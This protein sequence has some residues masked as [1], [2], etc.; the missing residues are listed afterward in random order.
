[1]IPVPVPQPPPG[2][3]ATALPGAAIARS[4]RPHGDGRDGSS[5]GR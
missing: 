2:A 5:A 3:L 1:V 4:V